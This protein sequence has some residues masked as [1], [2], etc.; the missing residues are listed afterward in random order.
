MT[1]RLRELAADL[2]GNGK[3]DGVSSESTEADASSTRP[4]RGAFSY[5]PRRIAVARCD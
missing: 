2:N 4:A 3:I 1:G 5:N